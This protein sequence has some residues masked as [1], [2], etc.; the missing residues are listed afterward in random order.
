MSDNS[1][2]KAHDE[3]HKDPGW[4]TNRKRFNA[5][6]RNHTPIFD[7]VFDR[8]AAPALDSYVDV[9][10]QDGRVYE[11]RLI[12]DLLGLE[13]VGRQEG[14]VYMLCGN[15]GR[16]KSIFSRH[17]VQ[18]YVPKRYPKVIAVYADAYDMV[19][20]KD[21][22]DYDKPKQHK[23]FA[24]FRESLRNAVVAAAIKSHKIIF[25]NE[26]ELFKMLLQS[27]GYD[28]DSSAQVLAFRKE[29]TLEEVL[30]FLSEIE[31]VDR[32]MIVIDNLDECSKEILEL[33]RSLVRSLA[34]RGSD[35]PRAEKVAVLL[36]LREYSIETINRFDGTKRY[37]TDNL[38]EPDYVKVFSRKIEILKQLIAQDAGTY[39]GQVSSAAYSRTAKEHALQQIT[40]S[41]DSTNITFFLNELTK[42]LLKTNN[43]R[44][45]APFLKSICA[46]NCK[47]LV[48]GLYNFLHS[49]KLPLTPLFTQAF[50]PDFAYREAK[51][52]VPLG[53]AVEC[54]MAIHYPFYDVN[55]SSICNVFN[56]ADLRA[57]NCY[58]NTLVIVRLLA[59]LQNAGQPLTYEKMR[60]DFKTLG[61]HQRAVDAA[62][63]KVSKFGLIASSEGFRMEDW[64]AK[65]QLNHTTATETYLKVL[66]S[67]PSY[68]QYVSEDVPMPADFIVSIDD[69]YGNDLIGGGSRKHRINSINFLIDFIESEE[70]LEREAILKRKRF[71]EDSFLEK[72]GIES[73][74]KHLWVAEYLRNKV[75]W[76]LQRAVPETA[77]E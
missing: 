19:Q 52:V 17:L 15:V 76:R 55:A 35:L 9:V 29:I 25:R 57:P 53:T 20:G 61:Y 54:L 46:G 33:T 39:K 62:F 45:F 50:L 26:C 43:E 66:I 37:A 44:D 2:S 63:Q 70:K 49:C 67:E 75:V 51:Q 8:G 59:R 48:A 14:R 42:Y 16:G 11:E 1:R 10:M 7:D 74:G 72:Y 68:L 56:V 32:V 3:V 34:V 24:E 22:T 65:T 77:M 5:L 21:D 64:N 38:P 36:P 31:G 28:M 60:Q 4:T 23:T 47:Y 13:K 27:K 12:Q 18:E 30:D 69:K 40:Y 41:V 58:E 71:N 6:F 73:D